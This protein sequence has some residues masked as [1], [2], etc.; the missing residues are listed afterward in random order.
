[1][2]ITLAMVLVKNR[3]IVRKQFLQQLTVLTIQIYPKPQLSKIKAVKTT[4]CTSQSSPN[5]SPSPSQ[6]ISNP[7]SPPPYSPTPKY[8]NSNSQCSLLPEPNKHPRLRNGTTLKL[9]PLLRM[10]WSRLSLCR[11][12]VRR[13]R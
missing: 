9:E 10:S 5:S 4:P 6:P 12:P 13:R 11:L 2:K 8:S 7:N 3:I 1:M